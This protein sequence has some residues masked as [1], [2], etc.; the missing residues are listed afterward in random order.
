[1]KANHIDFS[2]E[3]YEFLLHTSGGFYNQEHI[4][5]HSQTEGFYFFDSRT[6][7]DGYLFK[8]RQIE[9]ELSANML[10][11]KRYEGRHVRYKTIANMKMKYAGKVYAYKHDFGYAFPIQSAKDM[12][13]EDDY[14]CDCNRSL[15]LNRLYGDEVPIM[16]C[17]H[18][19]EI[20]KFKID[21][22]KLKE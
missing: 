12:F 3:K 5:K 9:K 8:L 19:I 11:S 20:V 15:F 21:Q 10:V 4:A 6:E 14:I 1:M 7:M 13:E 22:I 18:I 2:N 17:G 16:D